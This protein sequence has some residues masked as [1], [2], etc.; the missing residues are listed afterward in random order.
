MGGILS[1][2]NVSRLLTL[3]LG[4]PCGFGFVIAVNSSFVRVNRPSNSASLVSS[5]DL[6]DCISGNSSRRLK[7][8]MED[9]FE[10]TIVDI[11]SG[12]W[13]VLKGDARFL[14]LTMESNGVRIVEP[15]DTSMKYT[16]ASG[17]TNIHFTLSDILTDVPDPPGRQAFW[18]QIYLQGSKYDPSV[19]KHF[20]IRAVSCDSIHTQH[21]KSH[22]FQIRCGKISMKS[23]RIKVLGYVPD[24]PGQQAFWDQIY[25]QGSKYDPS[26]SKHF[27]SEQETHVPSKKNIKFM[28]GI[29]TFREPTY[30]LPAS[31]VLATLSSLR[32]THVPSKKNIKFIVG[33]L[34]FCEPTYALPASE[35]LATLSSLRETHVPNVP[36]PPGRQAFW[37]QI[38]LQ[39]SKYD[40]SVSKHFR[41]E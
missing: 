3:F 24:P 39:G 36:D 13:V 14:G 15:F 16:T 33:I 12:E 29:L 10:E 4:F 5:C 2:T 21:E 37:D 31:E 26:V 34:T 8:E 18:N 7:L 20:G 11:D 41:S 19:S 30:A 9:I 28:V 40:P 23:R 25:L 1:H 32:E 35:V 17:K 6:R 22:I 38:Y 27:R